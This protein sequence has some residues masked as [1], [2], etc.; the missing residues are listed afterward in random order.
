[1]DTGERLQL[2]DS[3]QEAR[4]LTVDGQIDELGYLQ[5][6]L[7]SH[8]TGALSRGVWLT[9]LNALMPCPYRAAEATLIAAMRLES[10]ESF[11]DMLRQ[12]LRARLDEGMLML[13][14][15][16]FATV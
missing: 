14:V 15:D 6:A 4:R 3:L 10:H 1:M 5:I 2:S 16:G 11:G 7:E 8:L 13:E 12:R 9:A